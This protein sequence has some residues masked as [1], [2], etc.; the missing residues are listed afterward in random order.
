MEK[1]MRGYS[2]GSNKSKAVLHKLGDVRARG[3]K[4]VMV[5]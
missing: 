1:V 3:R 5:G 4:R 2:K